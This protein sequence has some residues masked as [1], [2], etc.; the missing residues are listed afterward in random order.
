MSSHPAARWV[1]LP[2]V[3]FLMSAVLFASPASASPTTYYTGTWYG[4][5]E[6]L[7]LVA[8][9]PVQSFS[10]AWIAGTIANFQTND[11]TYRC[12]NKTTT[13]NVYLAPQEIPGRYVVHSDTA[14]GQCVSGTWT[15][16]EGTY[17]G[18]W[19]GATYALTQVKNRSVESDAGVVLVGQISSFQSTDPKYSCLNGG[20]I[21]TWLDQPFFPGQH[22]VHYGGQLGQCT[23]GTWTFMPL[24]Y[25]TIRIKAW[26]P[27]A[28]LVGVTNGVVMPYAAFAAVNA[29]LQS[30]VDCSPPAWW[31]IPTTSVI[32]WGEGDSHNS[33][34]GTWRA[35]TE[36]NFTWNPATRQISNYTTQYPSTGGD[37]YSGI[38]HDDVYYAYVNPLTFQV[39]TWHCTASAV[40]D[41]FTP[42]SSNGSTTF[43]TGISACTKFFPHNWCF[44][45]YHPTFCS[46][47]SGGTLS[48][49]MYPCRI[50][51]TLWGSFNTDGTLSINWETDWF[52]SYGVQVLSDTNTGCRTCFTSNQS[53]IVNDVSGWDVTNPATSLT[54]IT[55]GLAVW[56]ALA[57]T[58]TATAAQNL[59]T[60]CHSGSLNY[61]P[62]A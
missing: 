60:T 3:A 61:M 40:G 54:I 62:A 14:L 57:T 37:N 24:A 1:T 42:P 51:G 26:I 6:S 56:D 28:R 18:N 23:Y 39:T 12:L 34:E 2:F 9:V 48:T 25:Y 47:A 59:F 5:T 50:A 32:D 30:S 13:I 7:T 11:H 49:T 19:E 46:N 58:C 38:S 17:T 22:V 55:S 52:P 36:I 44:P 4:V 27:Q 20:S 43:T 35:T 45:E 10:D 29:T 21:N 53:T 33:Y 15:F 8:N 41:V 31:Q 16:A